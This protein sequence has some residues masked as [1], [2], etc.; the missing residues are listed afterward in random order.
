MRMA[1]MGRFGAG[2]GQPDHVHSAQ[3]L[4][5]FGRADFIFVGHG[6]DVAPF[7][8]LADLGR[9]LGV[10]VSQNDRP[11][12]QAIVDVFLAV[13]V[14]D[15]RAAA[16]FYHQGLIVAPV[17]EVGIDAQRDGLT[18]SFPHT[19]GYRSTFHWRTSVLSS[20]FLID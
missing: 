17:A 13:K 1:C 10:G 19:S 15:M 3:F 18:G 7:Q 9:D 20:D 6:K 16:V 4:Y 2:V 5:Q 8:G 12:G 11:P 14:P